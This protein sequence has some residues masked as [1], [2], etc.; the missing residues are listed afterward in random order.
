MSYLKSL[1]FTVFSFCCIAIILIWISANLNWGDGRWN[2]IIKNDG[3]GY[4]AYLPAIFIYHDLTFNFIDNIVNDSLNSNINKEFVTNDNGVVFNKYYAGTSIALLPFFAL[5]HITNWIYGLP[6]DGYAVYYRIFIQVAALFYLLFGLILFAKIL[7]FYGIKDLIIAI[8][9]TAI[10]FGTNIFYYVVSEPSMS[11]IYSFAFVNLFVYSFINYF[12]SLHLR[13]FIIGIVA[14]GMVTLIRPINI[15][16]FFSLPFLAGSYVA[17]SSGLK[18]LT[19]KWKVSIAGVILFIMIISV[20]LILYKIETGS[21]ILY[22][23]ANEGFNFL[24]PNMVKFMFSYRKGLFLY[25]PILFFSLFGMAYF[26]KDKFKFLSLI[27]FLFLVIYILSSWWM[28]YYGGSFSQRVMI[29]Y[30]IYFFIPFSMLLQKITFP[31][32]AILMVIFLIIVC[33]I[34]TYQYQRGYIHWSEMNKERYWDNFL[35]IDK[36]LKSTDK[37]WE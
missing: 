9:M 2:N 31:K 12:K 15:L 17:L 1:K 33:Q 8:S 18:C 25:T 10:V 36:V 13:F 20:Q 22:S 29:E 28:W 24:N 14:L 4:Y 7:G 16:I 6:L 26:I 21:L 32:M 19:N 30:Y 27:L 34:Q 35:R 5:G 11:H 23:Y 3:N 37:D